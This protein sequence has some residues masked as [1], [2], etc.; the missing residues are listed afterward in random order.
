M[1][2]Q[3]CIKTSKKSPGPSWAGGRE[4]V[5]GCTV[6]RFW[7]QNF[8]WMPYY[9]INTNVFPHYLKLTRL[10]RPI[11][12]YLLLWPTLTALWL[13][14]E[15][16]PPLHLVVIFVL[17]TTLMRS[18]GCVVNDY[19]DRHLDG[20]VK[21]TKQR[22]LARGLVS[23]REALILA[24]SLALAAFVL[25]LFTNTTTVYMAFGGLF[26]AVLYPF[27]KRHT[28]LPQV[29]LGAAFSWGI[30][31]A[32]TAVGTPLSE[33]TWLLYS[34]NILWTVHYDTL[35]AMVDRDD[36]L[37]IG[38]K[39]TAILFGDADKLM[40]GLLQLLTWLSWLLLGIQAELRLFWWLGLVI[41]TGCFIYQQW[42]IRDRN[43]DACFKA[44]LNNHW[45]GM[46]LFIGAVMDL[47][48]FQ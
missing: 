24:A 31:M 11:G 47:A 16:W 46:A 39:S 27:M 43:R 48:L 33:I 8:L 5:I 35:Y 18:A 13:A 2:P 26:L 42:L 32:Y 29:F 36:D 34:A 6:T 10:N 9:V 15:G 28:Y 4:R 40:V 44:F 20:H 1:Q 19:A 45:A 17:G 21:R 23:E 37:K 3:A 14:A 22:P 41:A 12:I 38:I 25:V 30:P 7:L